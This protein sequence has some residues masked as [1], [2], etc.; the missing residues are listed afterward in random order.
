MKPNTTFIVF[1]PKTKRHSIWGNKTL[2]EANKG[3]GDVLKEF[4]MKPTANLR[5][6]S[7]IDYLE[8]LKGHA[9]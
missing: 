6:R 7:L 2:A 4:T 1:N 3:R 8:K 9:L 5:N